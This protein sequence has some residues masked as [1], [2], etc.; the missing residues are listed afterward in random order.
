MPALYVPEKINRG[1]RQ[2]PDARRIR[3]AA[4][5]EGK[6]NRCV[7]EANEAV[8]LLRRSGVV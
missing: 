4:F 8:F 5:V 1:E 6:K 7:A 3:L 2:F